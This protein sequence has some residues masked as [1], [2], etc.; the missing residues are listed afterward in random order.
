ALMGPSPSRDEYVASIEAY[1]GAPKTLFGIDQRPVWS[2]SERDGSLLA[3]FP[4][5]IGDELSGHSVEVTSFQDRPPQ[6]KVKLF[7]ER[8]VIARLDFWDGARHVNPAP[9][10]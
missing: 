2:V 5:Q 8:A 4:V 7:Y 3:K 1:V 10:A 6:F 9:W